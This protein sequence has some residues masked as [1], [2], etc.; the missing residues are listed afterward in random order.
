MR[1]VAIALAFLLVPAAVVAQTVSPGDDISVSWS[2]ATTR[3][4]SP[5]IEG[6]VDNRSGWWLR[7]VQL[8]VEALD[9]AGGVVRREV[10]HV[11]GDVPPGSHI[12]FKRPVQGA[13]SYRVT[14]RWY[15]R[16]RGGGG[17]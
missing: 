8:D 4:G 15:E 14:I 12:Y 16:F 10:V 7:R 3:G 13:A 2:P 17:V 11:D 6:Y 5:A 1:R 9:P